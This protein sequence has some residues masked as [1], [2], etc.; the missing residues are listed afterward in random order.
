M[1]HLLLFEK[2][3][4]AMLLHDWLF[5]AKYYYL[6]HDGLNSTASLQHVEKI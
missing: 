6:T 4:N 2:K 1:D 3:K 5:V